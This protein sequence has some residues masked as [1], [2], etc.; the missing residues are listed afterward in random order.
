MDETG[1]LYKEE[2]SERCR[3]LVEL[4]ISL[5]LIKGF[6]FSLDKMFCA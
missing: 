4:P 1:A 3:F 5:A 6:V 2:K